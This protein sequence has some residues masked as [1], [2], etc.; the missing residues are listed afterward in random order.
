MPAWIDIIQ[1]LGLPVALV[2]FFIWQGK[3]REERLNNRIDGLETY[4][5]TTF[6]G[7]IRE[8]TAVMVRL[9]SWLEKNGH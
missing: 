3:A 2:V 1:S 6:E 5:R 9:E 8:N 7:V 4:L